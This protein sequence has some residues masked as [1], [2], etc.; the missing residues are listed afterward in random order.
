MGIGYLLGGLFCLIYAVLVAFF[1][2]IKKNAWLLKMVK[3]KLSKNMSDETA[4]KIS[5]GFG[6]LM[7]AVGVFLLVFGAIQG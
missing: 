2:G 4:A 6:L 7:G 5:L 1:G 3:M